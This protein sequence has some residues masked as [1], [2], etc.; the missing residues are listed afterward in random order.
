[1]TT[2]SPQTQ[3]SF[4][5]TTELGAVVV[6]GSRTGR[7]TGQVRAHSDGQG[8]SFVPRGRFAAGERV[9]VKSAAKSY[10]F[11]I[12][13]RPTP[14]RTRTVTPDPRAEAQRFVSRPDL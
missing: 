1:M 12:G 3:I 11:R 8:A 4:R 14:P 10:S 7:M 5:G 6:T 2:A 13:R 9:R